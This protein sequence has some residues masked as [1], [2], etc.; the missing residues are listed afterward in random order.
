MASFEYLKFFHAFAF[1]I[2]SLIPPL[3]GQ[4]PAFTSIFTA[5][6]L[7]ALSLSLA[8]SPILDKLARIHDSVRI[9][10]LLDGTHRRD[11]RG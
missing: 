8:L 2:L 1:I 11:C 9:E 10:R 3:L 7:F 5:F 4:F 6:K